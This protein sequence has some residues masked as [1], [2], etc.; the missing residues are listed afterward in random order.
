MAD[1][2]FTTAGDGWFVPTDH[3]RGPWDPD[4]CHAGP[5]TALLVRAVEQALPDHRLVRITVDLSR[6]IPMAGFRIK[7]EVLR[8]GRSVAASQAAIVDGDG[9]E[10]VRASASHV[11][12]TSEPLF[13]ATLD[14]SGVTTPR[15]AA[16]EPG[17]FPIRRIG[18][19]QPSFSGAVELRYPPG[20]DDGP[21]ATT[22]W[23]RTVA[24][25]PDEEPSPFQRIA[26]LAD[27]GNAFSRHAEADEMRFI[28]T[29]LTIALHR[30][31]VGEWLGSR[32]VSQ[33]QPSGIG[34]TD[35]LLF[36][37]EGPVGRALQTL[38]LR[39]P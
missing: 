20:E 29:D 31:P 38:L 16:A 10:R 37:D 4:A 28:N 11:A 8:A 23:M 6:P 30:D 17:P 27:C 14:N 15:L 24:I 7:T 1:S 25:L 32:A 34:L 35:A 21:G 19:G 22:V 33:W 5:P 39:S 18:H 26:P 9:A 3:A 12:T 36:D 13:A 2:F